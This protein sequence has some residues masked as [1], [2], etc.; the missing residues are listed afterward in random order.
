MDSN[1]LP[2]DS[3]AA[4]QA[5][6]SRWS[7]GRFWLTFFIALIVVLLGLLGFMLY[8]DHYVQNGHFFL[9]TR[10]GGIDVSHKTPAWARAEVER[11]IA[12]PL[13]KPLTVTHKA[14]EWKLDTPGIAKVDVEGM[15]SSAYRAGWDL[16][17]YERLYKR[18]LK[19]PLGV[20]EGVRFTFDRVRVNAFVAKLAKQ[21][22]RRPIDARQ[23]IAGHTIKISPARTGFS[24]NRKDTRTRILAALPEGKRELKLNVVPLPPK[25]TRRDF[26]QAI[27]INLSENTLY[28][29]SFDKVVKSYR[30]ATGAPGFRTPTGDWKVVGKRFNPTWHNPHMAWSAG[31]PESIGPG[32]GNP[33]GTRA[34]DL[35]APAIRIHGTY[36]D[37][38]IGSYASHGCI[39]MHIWESEEL[40]P[41]VEVG[42]PAYIR[43]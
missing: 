41:L 25:K 14:R 10:I 17:W 42:T 32:P 3:P 12:T 4:A 6:T 11:R 26:K 43:W 29:Y 33:L 38:S 24:L 16:P 1:A 20:D 31:M 9:G 13:L 2:I 34:L 5:R 28:L 18:W 23:Y 21:I 27:F 7:W 22:D 39:R 36:S 37:G 35:N 19:K 15:V 8:D 40:Y 30:V